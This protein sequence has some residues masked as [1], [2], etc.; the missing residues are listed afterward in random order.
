VERLVL[1]SCDVHCP[2][3]YALLLTEDPTDG[4]MNRLGRRS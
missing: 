3:N 1:N 4:I 2:E